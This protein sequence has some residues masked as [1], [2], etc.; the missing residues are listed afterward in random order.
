VF[1]LISPHVSFDESYPA[2]SDFVYGEWM[3]DDRYITKSLLDELKFFKIKYKVI[4][5]KEEQ[6]R[7]KRGLKLDF[8]D[9]PT[10]INGQNLADRYYSVD[11]VLK[12]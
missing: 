4:M 7:Q 12:N 3:L 10:K 8:Y 11:E 2:E 9:K 6:N 5:H 1:E